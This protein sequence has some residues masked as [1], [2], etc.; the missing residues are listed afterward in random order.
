MHVRLR[1]VRGEA[2]EDILLEEEGGSLP[3]QLPQG[4]I[5]SLVAGRSVLS[6]CHDIV[7]C[8]EQ[9]GMMPKQPLPSGISVCVC[10]ACQS[11]G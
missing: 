10:V 2:G 9:L 5:C 6:P 11:V 7:S 4:H 8:T 1:P 3:L